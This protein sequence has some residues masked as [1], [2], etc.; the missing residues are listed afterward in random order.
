[1]KRII[2]IIGAALYFIFTIFCAAHAADSCFT[3]VNDTGTVCTPLTETFTDSGN[4]SPYSS[5]NPDSI[6]DTPFPSTAPAIT[7]N[8]ELSDTPEPVISDIPSPSA[9]PETSC[10]PQPSGLPEPV[11]SVIPSPSAVPE[12]SCTP[13][14]SG[15]PEPVTSDAPSHST[16]PEA[17]CTP[18]P[19]GSPEPAVSDVPTSSPAPTQPTDTKEINQIIDILD[20]SGE[21]NIIPVNSSLD[22]IN[23]PKSTYI[24][25]GPREFLECTI[26]WDNI[27]ETDMTVPHRVTLHGTLLPPD[28][29]TFSDELDLPE[30]DF[31]FLLFEPD[32]IPTEEVYPVSSVKDAIIIKPGDDP[33]SFINNNDSVLFNTIHGDFFY[34]KIKWNNAAPFKEPGTYY[35]YGD[36]LL[37]EG[38]YLDPDGP[39]HHTQIFFVMDD[40]NIYLDYAELKGGSIICR[41]SKNVEDVENVSV[42]FSQNDTDWYIDKEK[43]YGYV[44]NN[45]FT[46]P[47]TAL[48]P[49]TDY[50]F[51]LEYDGAFTKTLHIRL[52]ED[53]I[54]TDMIEGDRDG[55]DNTEEDI[56]PLKQPS[57]NHSSHRPNRA[58]SYSS[59]VSVEDKTNNEDESEDEDSQTADATNDVINDNNK[60]TDV[61]AET[62]E[63]ITDTETV[64]T[65][66][67]LKE[68]EKTQGENLAFEKDSV[69][70]ELPS[71]LEPLKNAGNDDIISV[72]I[73]N[74]TDTINIE[75]KVNGNDVKNISGATLHLPDENTQLEKN[76]DIIPVQEQQD[77]EAV[78]SVSETGVYNTQKN[79]STSDYST[80]DEESED[81]NESMNIIL[82]IVSGLI[83]IAV[84]SIIIIIR[85]KVNH[86]RK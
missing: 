69:V 46:I 17:S 19:S 16:V 84:I 28:G 83:L 32:G 9:V 45:G 37:P 79:E 5:E 27:S 49:D 8:P 30:L 81:E 42:Y 41:W 50:Y 6:T 2:Y 74:G 60:I 64:I 26:R 65:G 15:S 38:V 70:L 21:L 75:V 35:V 56:P 10:T 31:S 40:D 62:E 67:R 13:Q 3:E 48:K 58:P 66:E 23:I 78:F 7:Q 63:M 18:D 22:S 85:K 33:D 1:M 52:H 11:I 80:E 54:I 59:D 44:S 29:Y 86:E 24:Q 72:K 57:G 77:G 39:Q 34:C 20:I 55:G 61:P 51:K 12:A 36:Y 25:T 82:M 14:P 47:T 68:M 76:G 73:E 53:Q 43:K 71:Q 4:S